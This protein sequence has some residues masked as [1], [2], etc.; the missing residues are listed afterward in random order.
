[1][2]PDYWLPRPEFE[3]SDEVRL[4]LNHLYA[5]PIES[6][7]GDWLSASLPVPKWVF[8]NWLA[9]KKGLLMHGSGDPDI[10]LFEPRTPD[11]RSPDDF[12]KQKAV[13]AAG[14]GIWSIFY[15]IVDRHRYP[16]RMMNGAVQFK[17]SGHYTPIRYFFSLTETAL[18]REPWREGTVHVLPRT[19]FERNMPFELGGRLVLEPQ[20]ANSRHVTPLAKVRVSPADFPFLQQIRGHDDEEIAVR[21]ERDP[22]GFPWL[23]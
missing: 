17:T 16:L 23:E 3:L 20:Y 18:K 9:D 8:L 11:D 5:E 4:E 21:S 19:G 14:D 15:A 7:G 10:T 2:I 22:R 12:S 6:G 13:F 1:M